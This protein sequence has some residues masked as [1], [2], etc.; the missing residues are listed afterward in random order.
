MRNLRGSPT[1]IDSM[2]NLKDVLRAAG[3]LPPFEPSTYAAT[4]RLEEETSGI[5]VGGVPI[6]TDDRSKIMI[7]GARVAAAADPKRERSC[8]WLDTMPV[9][10]SGLT[11]EHTRANRGR[12]RC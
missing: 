9:N 10:L 6:A 12:R 8:C 7:I 5:T 4:K 11:G 2:D 3:T 1:R